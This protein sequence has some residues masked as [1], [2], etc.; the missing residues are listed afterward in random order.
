MVKLIGLILIVSSLLSLIAGAY[1]DARYGSSPQITGN[2]VS[3]ILTQPK[4]G[5]GF[6]DYFEGF[7]LSYSII[8]LI[9]GIVFLFRV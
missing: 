9:M 3:N 2:V 6:F 8:S 4:T 1:I 5:L 7:A